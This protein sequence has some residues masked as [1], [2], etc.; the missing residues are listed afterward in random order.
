MSHL[1]GRDAINKLTGMTSAMC[2]N[3][4]ALEDTL[5]WRKRPLSD[6]EFSKLA[7][8]ICDRGVPA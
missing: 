8:N 4:F 7:G 3:A 6:A 2:D 5:H 1:R